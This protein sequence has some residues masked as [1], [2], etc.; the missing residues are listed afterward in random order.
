MRLSRDP[1]ARRRLAALGLAA[2]AAVLGGVLVGAGAGE[3]GDE[4]EGGDARAGRAPAGAA[5][6]LSLAQQ[7][8]QATILT[9]HGTEV[10]AYAR[11]ALRAGHVAGVILF[12]GNVSSPA[13]LRSLTAGVQ[14]NAG[15]SALVATD[16]EG[17]PIKIV[18]FAAP[19]T[20]QG[21]Q[22]TPAAAA[23]EAR[24]AA[25]DLRSLGVNVN[26]APVADVAGTGGPGMP[27]AGGSIL[28]GRAFPGGPA[29]VAALVRA[30]V[31]E[32]GARR[33]AAT[34]KHFPGLGPAREN[35]DDA[36][37]TIDLPRAELDR[38][39][40]PFRAAV[41]ERVPIVMASHA[42]F[43]A[44]DDRE[45]ASQSS[46]VLGEVLRRRLGFR[47]VIVTDSLEAEAVTRRTSI[48]VAAVRSLEAGV[49]LVLMT[50]SASWA[51]VHR[52]LLRRAKRSPALRARVR[53]AAGRV[54][55]LKRGLGLRPPPAK[56][57]GS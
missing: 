44:Y 48:E 7:V 47:G 9:F 21:A 37:V 36:P 34:A 35:T 13:Q 18:G 16:Q 55:T 6:R 24:A 1:A 5:D 3:E 54:L 39:L 51:D 12:G 53:E 43:T 14:R 57:A 45:I 38:A 49:D 23:A 32:Y 25:R 29:E 17:G 41:R 30:A 46:T 31:R 19:R 4:V 52:E 42:L 27:S 26:L 20:G 11:R 22:H 56:R 10:P 15:G 28:A 33:V 2:G 8:G 40:E 50:G